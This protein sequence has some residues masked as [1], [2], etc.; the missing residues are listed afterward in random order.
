MSIYNN[1][2]THSH[3]SV[4]FCKNHA[5]Y[6]VMLNSIIEMT[7]SNAMLKLMLLSN[8]H[9]INSGPLPFLT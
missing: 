9:I 7:L 4:A 2:H 6:H 5:S 8:L 3:E 1:L